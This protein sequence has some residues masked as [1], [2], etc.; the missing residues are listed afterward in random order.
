[1][2]LKIIIEE[3]KASLSQFKEIFLYQFNK[4]QVFSEMLYQFKFV[5]SLQFGNKCKIIL[6]KSYEKIFSTSKWYIKLY[7]I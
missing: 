2:H 3:K 4:K 1:M 5:S 6:Y 7:T